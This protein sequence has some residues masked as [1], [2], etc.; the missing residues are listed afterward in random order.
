MHVSHVCLHVGGKHVYKILDELCVHAAQ[1]LSELLMPN[2]DPSSSSGGG[3]GT[4][5]PPSEDKRKES[6]QEESTPASAL[7][8]KDWE[9]IYAN[10]VDLCQIH[11]TIG[12][13]FAHRGH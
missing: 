1:I 8:G 11:I 5:L 6:A 13:I 9:S 12:Q 10:R 2:S 7:A 4:D 3:G